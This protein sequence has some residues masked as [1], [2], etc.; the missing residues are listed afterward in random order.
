MT[1]TVSRR[2]FRLPDFIAIGPPRT[3]TTWLE[4]MLRGRVGLPDGVKETQYFLWRY[5]FG[6]EW[7]AAHFRDAPPDLPVGEFAPTYFDSAAARDRIAHDLPNCRII[8][9]LRDPAERLYSHYRLWRKIG[10]TKS[11]F[12]HAA[13]NH[14][15]LLETARY[16]DHLK[17]W[18]D[19]F[20][21]ERVLVLLHDDL[22][23]DRQGFLD[24]VCDFIGIARFE[25]SKIVWAESR[26]HTAE[27]APRSFRSA[28]RAEYVR[29][30]LHRYRFYRVA[31]FCQPIFDF[32]FS[33][34]EA[35]PPLEPALANQIRQT[36]RPQ[37]EALEELI[38]RDLS[39]WK[40]GPV[41]AANQT[42]PL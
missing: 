11:S 41:E 33:G 14:R 17:G 42:T 7:Y 15:Q 5:E 25:V 28:R 16:A 38:E 13:L 8:C 1:K 9:T 29:R 4:R 27:R 6:L 24:Q 23:A 2:I 30:K 3:A 10:Y 37:T 18:F 26:V 19:R 21:R 39:D 34:G 12:E 22:L 40:N 20:E 32:C 36:L 35:F 31:D